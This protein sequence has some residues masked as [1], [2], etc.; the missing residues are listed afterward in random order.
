MH[1]ADAGEALT[2]HGQSLLGVVF[3]NYGF[4]YV[5]AGGHHGVSG[6][7][8]LFFGGVVDAVKD[9]VARQAVVAARVVLGQYVVELLDGARGNCLSGLSIRGSLLRLRTRGSLGDLLGLRVLLELLLLK[10]RLLRHCA[11]GGGNRS[12]AVLYIPTIHERNL[13]FL[14]GVTISGRG[15]NLNAQHIAQVFVNSLHFF[16]PGSGHLNAVQEGAVH[17][18]GMR[19]RG[20]EQDAIT[21]AIQ[22]VGVG[23]DFES[24]RLAQAGDLVDDQVLLL[25]DFQLTGENLNVERLI[26]GV[27]GQHFQGCG[28]IVGGV[29][30]CVALTGVDHGSCDDVLL[31]GVEG[32]CGQGQ[33]GA[34]AATV[35]IEFGH[36]GH[37]HCGAAAQCVEG[38]L[39][40]FAH[41]HCHTVTFNGTAGE[42]LTGDGDALGACRVNDDALLDVHLR[43][44]LG[45]DVFDGGC[46]CC[47]G[48]IVGFYRSR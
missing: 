2:T 22:G 32:A 15:C 30:G 12:G 42:A 37:R 34:E 38:V 9:G 7:V 8:G 21:L 47:G 14:G 40:V 17:N 10:L 46:V 35:H 26:L 6:V 11:L 27:C 36:E 29:L 4:F 48:G 45:S 1:R 31:V 3:G 20:S 43:G 41:V 16:Q 25:R 28:G 23:H 5:Q 19:G 13:N 33:L 44:G 39:A 18:V 24:L